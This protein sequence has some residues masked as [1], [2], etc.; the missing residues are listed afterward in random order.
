MTKSPPHSYLTA[1]TTAAS[2]VAVGILTCAVTPVWAQSAKQA[3]PD[4]LALGVALVPEFEGSSERNALPALIGRFAVGS[5]TLRLLGNSAQ[6]NLLPA[7]SPWA[8]GPVLSLRSSRDE[9]VKDAV[10]KRL[11]PV[12]TTAGAGAFVEYNWSGLVDP[13]DSLTAGFEVISGKSGAR[14]QMSI[15]YQWQLAPGLR[16]NTSTQLGMASA[17]YQQTYFDVDADNAARSGLPRYTGERGMDR[18]SLAIGASY[19]VSKDWLLIGRLQVTRLF[20]D[21][22]DSPIVQLR[23]DRKQS[24]FVLSVGRT[25]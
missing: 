12:D 15:G 2:L 17:K 21:A 9:D 24:T 23:G 13:S 14:T 5:T 6:W 11:R 20:G 8:L 3:P 22:G 1:L 19:D 4:F 25:F 18:A 10:V 7:S 16:I